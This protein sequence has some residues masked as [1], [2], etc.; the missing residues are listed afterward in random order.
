MLTDAFRQI[1][2]VDVLVIGDFLFDVYTKG[3]VD[4]I[5]PEAPVP[6]LLVSEILQSPGGAGNVALNLQALGAQVSVIGRV[7]RDDAGRTLQEIFLGG[8]LFI[9][10]GFYTP[11][12]NRFLADGQQLMRADYETVTPISREVEEKAIAYVQANL[13]RYDIVAVSDYGKGFLSNRLL[14]VILEEG[15]KWGVKVIVDPK[16]KEFAKYDQAYLIKPNNKEAYAAAGCDSH[17][18][19]EEVARII[20]QKVDTQYLLITRSDKGMVLFSKEGGKEYFPVQKKDV[21]DVTG[22]GDTVLAMIT[23]GLA[24]NLSFAQTVALANIAASIAIEQVGCAVVRLSEVAARLL[25]REPACKIF[26][27]D[28]HLFALDKVLEDSEVT[29]L[30]LNQEGEWYPRIQEASSK[31][32]SSKLIVHIR[33]TEENKNFIHLLAAM[34][35][36]D[37]VFAREQ[38]LTTIFS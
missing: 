34:P 27:D 16:G 2:S 10:E 25:A 19:I 22:A 20:F 1:E 21:L 30:D 24:N 28:T 29:I 38:I 6:V 37:F 31:K 11:M 14:N 23:F 36:V 5:S 8:E 35:E 7:G 33:P 9:Q 12:K 4:R 17:V 32:G 13:S 18:S 26:W 3:N 15:K